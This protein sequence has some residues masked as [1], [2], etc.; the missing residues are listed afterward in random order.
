MNS[1]S[2]ELL[3]YHRHHQVWM[4]WGPGH[5][6]FQVSPAVLEELGSSVAILS[7]LTQGTTGTALGKAVGRGCTRLGYF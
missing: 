7:H 2:E 4:L 5:S 6:W 3:L 1:T